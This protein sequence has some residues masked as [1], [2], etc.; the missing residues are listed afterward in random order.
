MRKAH[1]FI[2]ITGQTFNRL[3]ALRR[4]GGSWLCRC[5]CGNETRVT[6]TKLRS[7]AT[8]SCGCYSRDRAT[9]HGM[10]KTSEYI[11][12]QQIKERCY[13]TNKASYARHPT[14]P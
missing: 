2:D 3:T 10:H 11:I 4:E 5:S 7:G 8:K 1:N 9:R 12:Y 6:V 13:N 14:T